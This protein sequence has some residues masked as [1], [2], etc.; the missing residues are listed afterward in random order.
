MTNN[1]GDQQ[2]QQRND[3]GALRRQGSNWLQKH[4]LPQLRHSL[5]Q[6]QQGDRAME[7][8]H[9]TDHGCR[10]IS[11]QRG[12]SGVAN[13]VVQWRLALPAEIA[14]DTLKHNS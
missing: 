4:D 10:G 5:Q 1:Q 9:S 2:P 7:S 6:E 8:C 12:T 11:R 13:L 3:I 14:W